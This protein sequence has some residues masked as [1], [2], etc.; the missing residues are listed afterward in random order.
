M[1]LGSLSYLGQRLVLPI[2]LSENGNAPLACLVT[3]L[4]SAVFLLAY[5]FILK[6][7]RRKQRAE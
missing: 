1:N 6:P 4:P 5:Q 7:R 3:S 2:V